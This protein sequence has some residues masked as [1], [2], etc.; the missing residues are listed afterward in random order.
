VGRVLVEDAELRLFIIHT[1]LFPHRD[2]EYAVSLVLFLI[3]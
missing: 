3:G 1:T 2:A